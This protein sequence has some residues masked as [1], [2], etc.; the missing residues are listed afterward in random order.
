[1]IEAFAFFES[2]LSRK[3]LMAIFYMYCDDSGKYRRNPIV[4][5]SAVVAQ[6]ERL[7]KFDNEWKTLLR[8]HDLSEMKMSRVLDL[9]QTCGPNMPR[10]QRM[11]ERISALLPFADCIN[12]NLELGLAQAWDVKG[13]N[14]LSLE[15]KRRLGGS[16]DPHQLAFIRGLLEVVRRLRPEDRVSVIFDDDITTAW[17]SYI[18]YRAAGKVEPEIRTKAVGLTFA[19]SHSFPGIQAADMVAFL[20]RRE[21][22]KQFY[23][24][25]NDCQSLYDYLMK[26]SLPQKGVMKWFSMFAD[27]RKMVDLAN[28][29]LL[30]V[31]E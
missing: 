27:E 22:N 16:H 29:L 24:K 5:I 1:M 14:N 2:A 18:H 12:N 25:C 21:A 30:E 7:G 9:N 15:A 6:K 10:G 11:E 31:K 26:G 13:Y 19:H 20:A 17:D 8:F 4:S 3:V 28:A 23:G